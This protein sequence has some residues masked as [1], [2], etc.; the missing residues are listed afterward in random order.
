MDTP[1]PDDT[2]DQG[3]LAAAVAAAYARVRGDDPIP[4]DEAPG[5]VRAAHKDVSSRGRV[6]EWWYRMVYRDGGWQY[7][8][9]E[10]LERAARHQTLMGEVWA[11]ELLAEHD[12]GEPVDTM[13]VAFRRPADGAMRLRAVDFTRRRD[14]QLGV[15]LPDGYTVVVPNPRH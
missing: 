5:Q 7:V 15:A 11:G 12:H 9:T 6:R 4:D 10:R 1:T 14:G 13:Y 8:A 3:A 2:P